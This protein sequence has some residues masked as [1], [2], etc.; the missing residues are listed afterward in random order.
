MFLKKFFQKVG[1]S[2]IT[3]LIAGENGIL[4]VL[5]HNGDPT[6][7]ISS[8]KSAASA[9]LFAAITMAIGGNFTTEK[10][11]IICVF[12]AVGGFLLWVSAHYSK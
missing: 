5:K 2:P 9:L 6:S 3:N 11:L 1:L 8:K 7:K 12:T 10:M 4:S